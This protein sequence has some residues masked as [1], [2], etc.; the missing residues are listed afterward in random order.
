M[1]VQLQRL[2]SLPGPWRHNQ[3]TLSLAYP[4]PA[5]ARHL[6][7]AMGATDVRIELSEHPVGIVAVKPYVPIVVRL[8]HM[9]LVDRRRRIVL[10]VV[11]FDPMKAWRPLIA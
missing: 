8:E 5:M 11:I 6:C 10:H 1:R 3:L 2:G 4:L 9:G 7:P